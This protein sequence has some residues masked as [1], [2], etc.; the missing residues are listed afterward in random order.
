[1]AALANRAESRHFLEEELKHDF[2]RSVVPLERRR[3]Q[4]HLTLVWLT[5]PPAWGRSM[6]RQPPF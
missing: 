5:G 3:D 6:V 4:V 2:T 1:M